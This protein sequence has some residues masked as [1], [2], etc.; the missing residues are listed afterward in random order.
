MVR[1]CQRALEKVVEV[2]CRTSCA[3]VWFSQRSQARVQ[4]TWRLEC[5]ESGDI[6]GSEKLVSLVRTLAN[7]EDP[8]TGMRSLMSA[9]TGEQSGEPEVSLQREQDK[10]K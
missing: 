1:E 9:N 4:S 3:V 6:I 10:R 8:E 5:S 2:K 7:T